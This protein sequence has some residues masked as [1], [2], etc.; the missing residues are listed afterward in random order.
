MLNFFPIRLTLIRFQ[1]VSQGLS[2]LVTLHQLSLND[3]LEVD[4]IQQRL[5]DIRFAVKKLHLVS[6]LELLLVHLFIQGSLGGK[7]DACLLQLMESL[8]KYTLVAIL[9]ESYPLGPCF[10]WLKTVI[11]VL[12]TH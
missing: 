12:D 8:E 1:F 5:L 6:F 11:Y 7:L 9:C 3:F 10:D 2:D 4:L